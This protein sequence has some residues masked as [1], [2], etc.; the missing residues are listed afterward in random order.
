MRF[1][2]AALG[3]TLK[4]LLKMF[5]TFR[6]AQDTNVPRQY[7]YI[8]VLHVVSWEPIAEYSTEYRHYIHV[9]GLLGRSDLGYIGKEALLHKHTQI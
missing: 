3:G 8:L 7:S 2:T 5:M 9:Y 4:A 1:L 6:E